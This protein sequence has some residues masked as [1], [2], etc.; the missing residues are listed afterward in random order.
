MAG[1]QPFILAQAAQPAADAP[2]V[3]AEAPATVAP[4]A[5]AQVPDG[6]DGAAQAVQSP[7]PADEV[8][9]QATDSF[10]T[11]P[12]GDIPMDADIPASIDIPVNADPSMQFMGL[13]L[14][15]GLDL[16]DKGGPV[17]IIL[18]VM[19]IFAV[20]VTFLKLIQFA[21]YRVGSTS[22]TSRALD[23]WIAGQHQ[24]AYDAVSSSGTPSAVVVAHGMRGLLNRHDEKTVREDV[25]R[26]AMNQLSGLRSYM[27]VIDSTVQIA[28]LLGLFGTVLGMISAFQALQDAGAEADPTVLAGGIWVALLTTAVGLAVAIP[29]AFVNTWFEGRIEREKENMEAALTGLFTRKATDATVR[30]P[31]G[32]G[33]A[34]VPHAAE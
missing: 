29:M 34:R 18:M 8:L 33:G 26:V 30:L 23:L 19:S 15:Q 7:P 24:E 17:V 14:Q 25:E 13:D 11:P 2:T 21:W 3:G 28:P 12:S 5:P 9:Q 10:T 32:D 27:R 6:A 22:A 4:A 1:T 20:T 31:S 16:I